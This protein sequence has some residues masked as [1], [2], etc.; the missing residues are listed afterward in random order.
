MVPEWT[1]T[2]RSNCG[3][4]NCFNIF[5]DFII[6][7]ISWINKKVLWYCW[8]T[9]QTWRIFSNLVRVSGT[10]IDRCYLRQLY[11]KT[12]KKYFNVLRKHCNINGVQFYRLSRTRQKCR[13]Q[14]H[15][16][17]Y[18]GS[19][20]TISLLKFFVIF[21]SLLEYA[22]IIPYIGHLYLPFIFQVIFRDH[23]ITP[24][25]HHLTYCKRC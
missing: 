3:N 12:V 8:C 14:P 4:F 22:Y 11:M 2:C 23:P 24:Q 10:S 5:C 1:E 16:I 19:E 15:P 9:V 18:S 6:V 25:F 13:V 7:C 21:F 20:V 17:S